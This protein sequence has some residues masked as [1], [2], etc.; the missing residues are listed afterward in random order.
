MA[1][2][3]N[4]KEFEDLFNSYKLEKLTLIDKF[5]KDAQIIINELSEGDLDTKAQMWQDFFSSATKFMR[6]LVT[7]QHDYLIDFYKLLIQNEN[8][9]SLSEN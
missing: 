9:R 8:L 3:I 1:R 6:I 4:Q 2:I 5:Q 7:E